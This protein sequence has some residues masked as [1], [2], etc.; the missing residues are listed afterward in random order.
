MAWNFNKF[1][2]ELGS[3]WV[4]EL[5]V[6]DVKSR[7]EWEMFL[8]MIL[9]GLK[10]GFRP[11][12]VRVTSSIEVYSTIISELIWSLSITW[13]KST[14]FG[15]PEVVFPSWRTFYLLHNWF[16][17]LIY[18]VSSSFLQPLNHHLEDLYLRWR[19]CNSLLFVEEDAFSYNSHFSMWTWS[20]KWG[21][22]H[23]LEEFWWT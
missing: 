21:K 2:S 1:L 13:S 20:K 22:C 17:Q 8:V 18:F 23:H 5:L 12:F 4:D 19:G 3:K 16:N 10:K 7:I 6:G 11:F 9:V 15:F 14:K